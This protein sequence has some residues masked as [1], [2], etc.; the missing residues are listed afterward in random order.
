LRGVFDNQYGGRAAWS[1]A[2]GG[3]FF[4]QAATATA[5]V[6]KLLVAALLVAVTGATGLLWRSSTREDRVPVRRLDALA[7]QVGDDAS[8]AK[9]AEAKAATEVSAEPLR[10]TRFRGRVFPYGKK[11][12]TPLAGATVYMTHR[13]V[14]MNGPP[15]RRWLATT[16]TDSEGRFEFAWKSN[17]KFLGG[18]GMQQYLLYICHEKRWGDPLYI[19]EDGFRDGDGLVLR[20]EL[21]DNPRFQ[22]VVGAGKQ[23]V[24]GARVTLLQPPSRGSMTLGTHLGSAITDAQGY[25]QPEWPAWAGSAIVRV[26]RRNRDVLQWHMDLQQARTY[27]P[28][29]LSLDEEGLATV[30][31]K[32]I[33]RNGDPAG[34]VRVFAR[35]SWAPDGR[36]DGPYI[37]V[38]HGAEPVPLVGVTDAEGIATFRFP[39]D[40]ARHG[41]YL[42]RRMIALGVRDGLPQ[43]A[44]WLADPRGRAE[45]EGARTGNTLPLLRLGSTGTERPMFAI[46]GDDPHLEYFAFWRGRDG[47]AVGV[48][49]DYSTELRV[50]G[51]TIC[52]FSDL[53]PQPGREPGE[54]GIFVDV[55]E[56]IGWAVLDEAQL[57]RCLRGEAVVEFTKPTDLRDLTVRVPKHLPD[58]EIWLEAVDVPFHMG[59][60]CGPGGESILGL[61]AIP[62]KWRVFYGREGNRGYL[63][64][65]G[66]KSEITIRPARD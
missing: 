7:T 61:P 53:G 36:T 27:D 3:L 40:R 12:Q 1:A 52:R 62:G 26:V 18:S 57:A 33:D 4:A 14:K 10:R 19:H 66:A 24:E 5:G 60:D 15:N 42:P 37:R 45:E 44:Q 20:V 39:A 32:V 65:P 6:S 49:T 50:D 56:R 48:E 31:M 13:S 17:W 55:G 59:V 30:R 9:R 51:F 22:F 34:G 21:N 43:I 58:D 64:E 63:I 2:I 25:A 29:D 35:G 46:R 28:Y 54:L 41:I 11:L 16:T 38:A 47:R 23:G 8:A